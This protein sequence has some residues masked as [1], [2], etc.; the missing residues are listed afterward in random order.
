VLTF[1]LSDQIALAVEVISWTRQTAIDMRSTVVANLRELATPRFGILL[2]V[3]LAGGAAIV[4][5]ARRP[6]S[7][8]HLLAAFLA[9]RGIE[10]SEAMTLEEALGRLD[11]ES[12]RAVAPLVALY[13]EEEFSGRHDP[14]RMRALKKRLVELRG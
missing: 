10:V 7:P 1:G 5:Y 2:F 3:L 6:R 4:V 8:F 9:E 14:R 13:E 12:A 11:P